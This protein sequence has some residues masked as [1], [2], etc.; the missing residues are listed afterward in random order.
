MAGSAF[1]SFWTA[2]ICL[3]RGRVQQN[4][5]ESESRQLTTAAKPRAAPATT[6]PFWL[7]LLRSLSYHIRVDSLG[8]RIP[9]WAVPECDG[10]L[11]AKSVYKYSAG[12]GCPRVACALAEGGSRATRYSVLRPRV[13]LTARQMGLYI[14]RSHGEWTPELAAQAAANPLC[15]RKNTQPPRE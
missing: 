6:A 10:Q 7:K 5:V 2:C 9:S 13:I 8:A 4:M 1:S 11:V 14:C 15:D 12:A 3:R